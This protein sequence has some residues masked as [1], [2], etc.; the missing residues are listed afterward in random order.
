MHHTSLLPRRVIYPADLRRIFHCIIRHSFHFSPST[1]PALPCIRSFEWIIP[2]HIIS[3][4]TTLLYHY[5]SWYSSGYQY[6]PTST[7]SNNPM[8]VIGHINRHHSCLSACII[9]ISS[10]MHRYHMMVTQHMIAAYH[11]YPIHILYHIMP[12]L[13]HESLIAPKFDTHSYTHTHIYIILSMPI[14]NIIL[15]CSSSNAHPLS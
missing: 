10:P 11:Y 4:H 2:C 8:L 12:C 15:S 1:C 3:Y 14:I 6:R 13:R 9:N 7:N 5:Q